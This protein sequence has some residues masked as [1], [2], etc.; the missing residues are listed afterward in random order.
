LQIN[1]EHLAFK[2][3]NG[4]K[5]YPLKKSEGEKFASQDLGFSGFTKRNDE[6]MNSGVKSCREESKNFEGFETPKS[7]R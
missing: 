7:N 3:Q 5:I 2:T 1:S 6:E 4:D